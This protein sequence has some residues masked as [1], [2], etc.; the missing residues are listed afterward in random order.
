MS[1]L[2]TKTRSLEESAILKIVS[3]PYAGKQFRLLGLKI[4]IG[5][6]SDCDIILK[7]NIS[8]SENHAL[9]TYDNDNQYSIKS[10]D[11]TNPVII[12]KQPVT[13][14]K[15]KEKDII[16]IGKSQFLFMNKAPLP[17]QKSSEYQKHQQESLLLKQKKSKN[18]IRVGFIVFICFAIGYLFLDQEVKKEQA[19]KG[20]R[21]QQEMLEEIDALKSLSEKEITK[22]TLTSEQKLARVTFIKGFRDYRKGYYHRA[23]KFF[24]QC[25]T[26]QNNHDLCKSYIRKSQI[27]LEKLIQKKVILGKTY[28]KNKQYEACQATFKSIEIMI[29]NSS[30]PVYKEARE[31]RKLCQLKLENKI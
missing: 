16:I 12:N 6:S 7:N 3:G 13:H 19:K 14:H 10:L 5:L 15:L 30:S 27:Q 11:P 22:K 25:T 31:N 23:L 18:F 26:I 2:P 28:K 4:S 9:I 29:Q 24:E 17:V 21:T 20:L 8:C 1:H